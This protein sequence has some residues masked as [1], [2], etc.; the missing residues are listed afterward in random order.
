M[1]DACKTLLVMAGRPA[2]GF[3][4]EERGVQL[5][6][7]RLRTAYTQ[8]G[9][10]IGIGALIG[11]HLGGP[12]AALGCAYAGWM[13]GNALAISAEEDFTQGRR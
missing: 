3:D 13:I 5:P 7:L 2:T 9:L 8:K 10:G 11:S 4:A 1:S 6:P 12:I